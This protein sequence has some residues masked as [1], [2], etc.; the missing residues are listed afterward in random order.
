MTQLLKVEKV[1]FPYSHLLNQNVLTGCVCC[2]SGKGG[3]LLSLA[4]G[5]AASAGW[6][7]HWD[8]SQAGCRELCPNCS[9]HTEGHLQRHTHWWTAAE[10]S[11]AGQQVHLTRTL[12]ALTCDMMKKCPNI[13]DNVC[14]STGSW[15]Q[16]ILCLVRMCFT[17]EL[18]VSSSRP[19]GMMVMKCWSKCYRMLP[20]MPTTSTGE[21]WDLSSL[22]YIYSSL[23]VNCIFVFYR[24]DSFSV[25]TGTT[26]WF[27]V[28]LD[29]ISP[30][31]HTGK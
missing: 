1:L 29:V 5:L 28:F 3:G 19:K 23:A 20:L 13:R 25:A 14:F 12:W 26:E 2:R 6:Q 10:Q 30:P 7:R 27:I 24:R 15:F 16:W 31:A 22:D 18:C 11:A 9:G 4:A 17:G 8:A 21:K